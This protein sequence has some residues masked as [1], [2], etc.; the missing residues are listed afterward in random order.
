MLSP[1]AWCWALIAGPN[2]DGPWDMTTT[3]TAGT[4]TL[5][6]DNVMFGVGAPGQ[7]KVNKGT[8]LRI[9]LVSEPRG[10][11]RSPLKP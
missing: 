8:V 9:G 4:A 5:F 10:C 7:G 2:I 3:E 6:V 11:R 1:E